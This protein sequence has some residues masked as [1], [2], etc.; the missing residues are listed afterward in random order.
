MGGPIE[1]YRATNGWERDTVD[2]SAYAGQARVWVAF[3]GIAEGGGNIFLDIVVV[4][5]FPPVPP[6]CA[7]SPGPPDG[8]IGVDRD[9]NVSWSAAATAAGYKFY[10]GTRRSAD[11]Y[12]QRQGPGQHHHL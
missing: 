10:L 6:A 1:R 12:R 4:A 3:Q 11:Q 7:T 5:D 8:A 2:L 9:M